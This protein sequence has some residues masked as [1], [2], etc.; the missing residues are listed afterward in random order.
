MP[1]CRRR[2]LPSC[3]L[4][5]RRGIFWEPTG[6]H[7]LEFQLRH[8]HFGSAVSST[9]LSPILEATHG[10]GVRI[11]SCSAPLPQVRLCRSFPSAPR[12]HDAVGSSQAPATMLALSPVRLATPAMANFLADRT[13]CFRAPWLRIGVQ[14]QLH[15][16]A[17]RHGSVPGARPRM[18]PSK[19]SP[20]TVP[21]CRHGGDL[22]TTTAAE[23]G[24]STCQQPRPGH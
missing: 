16:S 10:V 18:D 12:P 8:E 19:I 2:Y 5:L 6:P 23:S 24:S 22:P 17:G 7:E 4:C 1:Q 20:D 11:G 9:T 21:K 3:L 15:T 14:T 13:A